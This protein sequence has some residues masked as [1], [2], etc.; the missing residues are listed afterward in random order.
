MVKLVV[1]FVVAGVNVQFEGWEELTFDSF[2][3]CTI[4]SEAIFDYIEE[5]GLPS[6]AEGVVVYCE[7]EKTND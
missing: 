2:D 3:R 6:N 5:V 7:K 1:L 4:A